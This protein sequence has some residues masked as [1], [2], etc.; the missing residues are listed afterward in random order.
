MIILPYIDEEKIRAIRRKHPIKEI[1]ERYVSLTKK[2][3]DYW[4]LCPFHND[5]NASMSVSTRL[6]MFQCFSCKKAGNVFNFIANIEHISYGEAI[7]KLAEEDGL[8]V[9]HVSKTNPHQ[10]DYEILSLA[11][12]YY[13]NNINS[14]L[15]ENAIKYLT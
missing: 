9:G 3:E 1:V 5:N 14:A 2:G 11:I 6:D 12:K 7:H 8:E 10:K 4:G 15:G 13:Q